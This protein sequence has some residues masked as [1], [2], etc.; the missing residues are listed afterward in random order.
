MFSIKSKDKSED[1][2]WDYVDEIE[3]I[4]DYDQY[5]YDLSVPGTDSFMI[6]EGVL[7]HNTLKSFHFSGIAAMGTTNLG[8]ARMKELLS[9]SKNIKTPKMFIYLNPDI[10]GNKNIANKISNRIKHT[11]LDEIKTNI[12]VHFDPKPLDNFMKEDNI[13]KVFHVVNRNKQ[14]ENIESYPWLIR[15]TCDKE[16]MF[17]K[18]ITLLD[19]KTKFCDELEKKY[20]DIKNMSR[21]EKAILTNVASIMVLSNSDNDKTPIIHIRFDMN[22]VSMSI[23]YAFVNN[24]VEPFKL[25]GLDKITD[26]KIN[27]DERIIMFDDKTGDITNG[28]NNVL[29]TEGINM[30]D[31]RNIYGINL[32]KTYCNDIENIY[33]LFGIEAARQVL[34]KEFTMVFAGVGKINYQHMSILLD[35]MTNNGVVTSVDRHGMNKLDFE[36]LAGASFEKPVERL[37]NAAVFG[38]TDHLNS[39][40]SRIMVGMPMI[41]GTGMCNLILDTKHIIKSEQ[42]FDKC[43]A[44]ILES[45]NVIDNI[46]SKKKNIFVPL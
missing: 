21:D 19:I 38:E 27:I 12:S 25:K 32:N 10:M 43:N 35:T 14:T 28:T 36:P 8:V 22:K 45:N 11:T 26:V 6:N 5:V 23:I 33:E 17:T 40:S 20:N 1:I 7:V 42:M 30:T 9:F 16:K 46:I 31:I 41:G 29:Y 18:E 2:Y 3:E 4:D 24:I 34:Y 37:N 13:N 44:T 39:V 15:I